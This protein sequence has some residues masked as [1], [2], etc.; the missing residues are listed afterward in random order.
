MELNKRVFQLYFKS[1]ASLK[2]HIRSW[3]CVYFDDK[4][5]ARGQGCCCCCWRSSFKFHFANTYKPAAHC[6]KVHEL[7]LSLNDVCSVFAERTKLLNSKNSKLQHKVNKR[8]LC[9]ILWK[10]PDWM[11]KM[12]AICERVQFQQSAQLTMV[13]RSLAASQSGCAH[14]K[15]FNTLCCKKKQLN[16]P[17]QQWPHPSTLWAAFFCVWW[18]YFKGVTISPN[19][20]LIWI[21]SH[22]PHIY[23]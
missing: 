22:C 17:C 14:R 18:V 6:P 7:V 10:C 9:S 4:R 15:G 3:S 19:V 13:Q 16:L 12:Y 21:S 2:T 20:Y 5:Q 1:K 8:I 11:Y 23:R